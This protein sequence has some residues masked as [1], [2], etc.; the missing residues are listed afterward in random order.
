MKR[1]LCTVAMLVLATAAFAG[2]ELTPQQAMEKAMNCPVCSAWGVEPALGPTIRYN[3]ATTK[4]GFI[5]VMQ[6]SNEAMKPAFDKA[7]AECEK[8]A[9]GIATMNAEEKAKLCP[10]CVA[11]M[12]IDRKDVTFDDAQTALGMVRVASSTTPEGI[13]ALHEYA[14]ACQKQSDLM[15]QAAK[16]MQSKG[17]Q[18]AK[19]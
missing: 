18:K 12:T 13:K 5:E 4:T 1:V 15:Q 17:V 7:A 3:V 11:H 16:D 19:M 2:S 10:F 9:A 8:R 6:T 14:A